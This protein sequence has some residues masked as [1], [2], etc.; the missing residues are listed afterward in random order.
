M[1]MSFGDM[2]G[3]DSLLIQACLVRLDVIKVDTPPN[4]RES[5][6]GKW[7]NS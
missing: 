5:E 1:I 2:Y 3:D 6:E 4:K 7:D